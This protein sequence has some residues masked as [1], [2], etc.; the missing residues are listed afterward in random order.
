MYLNYISD[1]LDLFYLSMVFTE[2]RVQFNI[3]QDYEIL[4][5]FPPSY[6]IL[7]HEKLHR[8][9]FGLL[10]HCEM[11]IWYNVSCIFFHPAVL[12]PSLVIFDLV[13]WLYF[14]KEIQ[15]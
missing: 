10:N 8:L 15:N 5:I 3:L 9:L 4:P 1:I 2:M 6:F 7:N 12:K 11:L 13:M 14:Q